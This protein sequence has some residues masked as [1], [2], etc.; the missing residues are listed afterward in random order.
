MSIRK[1]EFDQLSAKY[2]CTTHNSYYCTEHYAE[3]ISDRKPHI[4]YK[5]E[6]ALTHSDFQLLQNEVV[7]RIEAL[8]HAKHQVANK[9]AQLIADIGQ[10]CMSSIQQLDEHIKSY[11][12]YVLDNNFD[13]QTLQSVTKILTTRLEV[14]ID[15]H[16]TLTLC[17]LVTQTI[18]QSIMEHPLNR[19]ED[20]ENHSQQISS[21]K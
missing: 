9:A 18:D 2:A 20:I 4:S 6:N 13:D 5:I 19:D 17:D 14:E 10:A 12:A 16:L 7:T 1:C 3:H 11:K 8:E 21:K 15:E